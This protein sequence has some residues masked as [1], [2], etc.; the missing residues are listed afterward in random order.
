MDQDHF[1]PQLVWN[2]ED[3]DPQLFWDAP[4][5]ILLM[6]LLLFLGTLFSAIFY[7]LDGMDSLRRF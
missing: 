6:G 7:Y 3:F 1:N 4:L 2:Q 5:Q